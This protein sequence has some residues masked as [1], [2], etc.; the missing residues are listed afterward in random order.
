MRPHSPGKRSEKEKSDDSYETMLEAAQHHKTLRNGMRRS[1]RRMTGSV[2]RR[3]EPAVLAIFS[4][5]PMPP[6]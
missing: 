5:R 6:F 4:G 2:L 3:I 1:G